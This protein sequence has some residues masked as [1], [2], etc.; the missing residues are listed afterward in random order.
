MNINENEIQYCYLCNKA[1]ED[2]WGE[3][4]VV[5]HEYADG[6]S[7]LICPECLES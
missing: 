6:F 2:P 3:N 1:I 5:S 7:A 4:V